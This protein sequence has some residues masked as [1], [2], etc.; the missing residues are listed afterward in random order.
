MKKNKVAL[1]STLIIAGIVLSITLMVVYLCNWQLHPDFRR[2][3]KAVEEHLKNKYGKE[4]EV[5]K[6]ENYRLS[7]GSPKMFRST[8]H[9]VDRSDLKFEMIEFLDET[10]INNNEELD[11][12][13]T[14]WSE[15]ITQELKGEIDG[16][17]NSNADYFVYIYHSLYLDEMTKTNNIWYGVPDYKEV[18]EMY[19]DGISCLVHIVNYTR[20]TQANE[21]EEI[22]K[23]QQVIPMV[24]NK[25]GMEVDLLVK[26][27][28]PQYKSHFREIT[29][30]YGQVYLIDCRNK[31]QI[32]EWENIYIYGITE[33][34]TEQEIRGNI[35]TKNEEY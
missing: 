29:N 30:K 13:E 5:T 23:I 19:P 33:G 6:V 10:L 2:Q 24:L 1:Y 20:L 28:E 26:Y 17:F 31:L 27:F 8:F 15:E 34:L 12:I 14:M 9:P 32:S 11:Y 35:E 21:K 16:V 22:K 7:L 25:K 3:A 4:F 18:L